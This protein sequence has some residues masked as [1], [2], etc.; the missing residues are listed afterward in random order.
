[1]RSAE[2]MYSSG[3]RQG[4]QLRCDIDDYSFV[5]NR[6]RVTPRDMLRDVRAMLNEADRIL[7]EKMRALTCLF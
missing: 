3:F 7:D 2:H 1:L 4:V 5:A 6:K